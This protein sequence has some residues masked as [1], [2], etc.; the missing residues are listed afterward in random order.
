MCQLLWVICDVHKWA[1][2]ESREPSS[3]LSVLARHKSSDLCTGVLFHMRFCFSKKLLLYYVVIQRY[4]DFID[5]KIT[6]APAF[7]FFRWENWG[8]GKW[9]NYPEW[10]GK[11]KN[12]DYFSVAWA[13]SCSL[14]RGQNKHILEWRDCWK[15][16]FIECY[17]SI[18]R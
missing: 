1:E 18:S 16:Y 14:G 5:G 2:K 11:W 10:G 17:K 12:I 9:V 7:P 15:A 8:P 3:S 4:G 6:S 13:F